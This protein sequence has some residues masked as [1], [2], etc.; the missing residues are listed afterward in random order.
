MRTG[1][2]NGYDVVWHSNG[3]LYLNGNAANLS[4]GNT[5]GTSDGCQTPS[6]TPGDQP[7]TLN[8]VTQGIYGG[9]PNPARGECVWGDGTIYSP[10]LQPLSN[11][12]QPITKY[13]NG[14]SSDGVAEYKSDAFN[15]QLRAT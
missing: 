5:P 15:G 9:H 10:A 11:F 13:V 2:R 14:G 4:Q 3:R 12:R 7:D 8:L 6:I 1:Y